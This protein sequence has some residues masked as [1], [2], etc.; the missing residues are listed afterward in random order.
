[1]AFNDVARPRQRL[2]GTDD[3]V[4]AIANLGAAGHDLEPTPQSRWWKGITTH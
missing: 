1:M 4:D 2:L 3:L